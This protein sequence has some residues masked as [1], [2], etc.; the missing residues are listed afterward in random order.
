[1]SL[2]SYG[3]MVGSIRPGSWFRRLLPRLDIKPPFDWKCSS[4]GNSCHDG[5]SND[6]SE[7]GAL[8][9]PGVI[10]YVFEKIGSS[11]LKEGLGIETVQSALTYL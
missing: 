3:A 7:S 8:T 6:R 9:K 4:I 5:C 2:T 1:M 10:R 11:I